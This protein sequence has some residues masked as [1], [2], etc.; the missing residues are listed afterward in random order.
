V[1]DSVDSEELASVDVSV[2]DSVVSSDGAAVEDSVSAAMVVE[3]VGSI[4]VVVDW[5]PC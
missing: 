3:L 4:V 5:Q 1:V 2:V